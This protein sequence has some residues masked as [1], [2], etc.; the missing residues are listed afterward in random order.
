M[1]KIPVKAFTFQSEAIARSLVTDV[2]IF[3]AFDPAKTH[4]KDVQSRVYKAVWDTG[5]TNSVV[6]DT[7]PSH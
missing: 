2:G 3:E 1:E 5:A 4:P 6:S 7:C